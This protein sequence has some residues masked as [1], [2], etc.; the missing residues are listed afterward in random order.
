MSFAAR[1]APVS[2]PSRAIFS[3][4]R[5]PTPWKRRTGRVGDEARAFAG[6]DHAQ[7]VGLVLVAGELGEE[8]VVADPGAGGELRSLR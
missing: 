7:P 6:A 1:S 5:G 8:L 3:A 4:P 2:I